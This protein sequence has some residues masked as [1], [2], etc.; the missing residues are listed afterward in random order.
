MSRIVCYEVPE[1]DFNIQF[2]NDEQFVGHLPDYYPKQDVETLR[3]TINAV[4][5][6]MAEHKAATYNPHPTDCTQEF[7]GISI[8]GLK[9]SG[10]GGS[11]P[12]EIYNWFK[13]KF[14]A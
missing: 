14:T 6:E 2:V 8:T 12:A 1:P 9:S 3:Q 10:S 4:A 5:T 11:I 7:A 13:A